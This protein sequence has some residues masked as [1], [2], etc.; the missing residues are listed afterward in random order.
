MATGARFFAQR[1]C[2]EFTATSLAARPPFDANLS[3]APG[4]RCVDR[5]RLLGAKSLMPGESSLRASYGG[6]GGAFVDIL[7]LNCHICQD[8]D[9]VLH[10]G[11]K[12]LPN[13][14][15]IFPPLF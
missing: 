8:I 12:S 1:P 4:K 13:S 15:I 2:R 3:K 11:H 5:R 14:K 6:F 10:D 9:G 7:P